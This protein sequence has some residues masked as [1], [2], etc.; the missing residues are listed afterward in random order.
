[1][2]KKMRG[3]SVIKYAEMTRYLVKQ[4]CL[5][6]QQ[7]KLGGT[8]HDTMQVP[9]IKSFLTSALRIPDLFCIL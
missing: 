5:G 1:M 3:A 7:A 2:V 8:G 9:L 6:R 4:R